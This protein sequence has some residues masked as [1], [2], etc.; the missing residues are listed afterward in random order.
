MEIAISAEI[1][2]RVLD[3]DCFD[4]SSK[5]FSNAVGEL[6]PML[7]FMPHTDNGAPFTLSHTPNGATSLPQMET[8]SDR[9][10]GSYYPP[11]FT[12]DKTNHETNQNFAVV[13][14]NFAQS[15]PLFSTEEIM[16]QANDRFKE[17]YGNSDQ[18]SA[19]T[20]SNEIFPFHFVGKQERISNNFENIQKHSKQRFSYISRKHEKSATSTKLEHK[21][22]QRKKE[23]NGNNLLNNKII[24]KNR[25]QK[26]LARHFKK[27]SSKNKQEHLE[28]KITRSGHRKHLGIQRILNFKTVRRKSNRQKHKLH[29]KNSNKIVWKKSFDVNEVLRR[30]Y[31]EIVNLL[32]DAFKM[33]H[34]KSYPSHH[35]HETRKDIYRHNLR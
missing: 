10:Q 31:E 26:N 22:F 12:N 15:G 16:N 3:L 7:E 27:A 18:Q 33:V 8:W 4:F 30:N 29:N 5:K 28:N 11:Y 20:L 6:N 19:T 14:K 9:E 17:D 1:V 23:N 21:L 25:F 2:F 34:K 35:E 24:V 13:N 32:F